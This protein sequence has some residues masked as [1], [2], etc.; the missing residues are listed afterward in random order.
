MQ[1]Q[2]GHPTF[3]PQTVARNLERWVRGQSPWALAATHG[4]QNQHG[5]TSRKFLYGRGSGSCGRHQ[6]KPTY[7]IPSHK[8]CR[9]KSHRSYRGSSWHWRHQQQ[10]QGVT[11]KWE[12]GVLSVSSVHIS[13]CAGTRV[14]YRSNQS[15]S[16][17]GTYMVDMSQQLESFCYPY[18]PSEKMGVWYWLLEKRIPPVN[19][20]IFQ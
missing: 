10:L 14:S 13:A 5:G 12:A 8:K 15:V 1:R 2:H 19:L 20:L 18:P 11:G 7:K 16:M 3:T 6:H 4:E 17:Y 9:L